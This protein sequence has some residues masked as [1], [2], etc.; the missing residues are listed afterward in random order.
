MAFFFFRS[1]GHLVNHKWENCLT[2]DKE[3]W[4]FRREAPLEDYL[5]D[6]ELLATIAETVR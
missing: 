5:T 4:G 6:A 1:I 2:L 3:S